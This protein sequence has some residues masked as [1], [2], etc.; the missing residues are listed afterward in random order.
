MIMQRGTHARFTV[1]R[2]RVGCGRPGP[3]RFTKFP[4]KTRSQTQAKRMLSYKLISLPQVSGWAL[5]TSF[6]LT[7]APKATQ[8][9]LQT[10]NW[11][12]GAGLETKLRTESGRVSEINH[13][14]HE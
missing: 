4:R 2:N 12:F 14:Q 6:S 10:C 7:C 8:S 11:D 5:G 3:G 9:T 13:L 1:A